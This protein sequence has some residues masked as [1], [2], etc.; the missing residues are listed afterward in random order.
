[1]LAGVHKFEIEVKA[2]PANAAA[3]VYFGLVYPGFHSY[4][5]SSLAADGGFGIRLSNGQVYSGA[6]A[7]G[8]PNAFAGLN[9]VGMRLQVTVDLKQKKAFCAVVAP[10][11]SEQTILDNRSVCW[12]QSLPP[13][14]YPAIRCAAAACSALVLMALRRAI[15]A[16]VYSVLCACGLCCSCSH[17][18]GRFVLRFLPDKK[19]PR[20]S[21]FQH[22]DWLEEKHEKEYTDRLKRLAKPRPFAMNVLLIAPPGAG[23]SA[24]TAAAASATQPHYQEKIALSGSFGQTQTGHFTTE[25]H[26]V[27]LPGCAV[28]I[29]D[30]YGV[31][32]NTY[33]HSMFLVP[34]VHGPALLF[35]LLIAR[36]CIA[37]M[38]LV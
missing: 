26:V 25:F 1:V 18:G 28:N 15:L 34:F 2:L 4:V 35:W 22:D 20:F 7:V 9:V 3:E 29:G 8:Q 12:N 23:K 13:V 17:G 30:T 10:N 14:V 37:Q 24:F 32:P 27:R 38:N 11:D 19:T 6:N 21:D 33:K 16:H 5:N 31:D 36:V